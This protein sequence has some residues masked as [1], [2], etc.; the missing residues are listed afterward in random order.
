MAE[1]YGLCY[2]CTHFTEPYHYPGTLED[3]PD[4]QEPECAVALATFDP[5][6]KDDRR[7]Y[8]VQDIMFGI[9]QINLCA[10]YKPKRGK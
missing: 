5:D 8:L 4:I 2:T 3:P 1:L 6:G 7:A 10:R 9:A